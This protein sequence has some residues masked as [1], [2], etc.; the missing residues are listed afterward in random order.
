MK[1]EITLVAQETTK[2]I[3][4]KLNPDAV[5]EGLEG[6]IKL[7]SDRGTYKSRITYSFSIKDDDPSTPQISRPW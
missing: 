3:T 7:I 6:L 1:G 5:K 4:I 2:T